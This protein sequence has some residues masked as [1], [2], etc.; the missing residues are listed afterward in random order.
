MKY[1]CVLFSVL[2]TFFWFGCK[3]VSND[4]IP[5]GAYAYGSYDSSGTALVRGWFTIIVSDSTAISGEW[6]FEP[7]G[8]P[9]R[10]G[11]QTGDGSLVG[12]INGEKF[13]IELNPKFRN[14]NLQLNGTLAMGRLSGQWTWIRYDGIANQGTF[15]AVRK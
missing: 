1:A 8:N 12:G 11:P 9:Q 15:K 5:D 14:N 13:W 4:S 10:I 2:I 7:I 6:H 3:R